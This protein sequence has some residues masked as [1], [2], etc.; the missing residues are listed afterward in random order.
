M[1]V[2]IKYTDGSV[3]VFYEGSTGGSWK[4][5]IYELDDFKVV[6]YVNFYNNEWWNAGTFHID[7]CAVHY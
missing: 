4:I 1:K 3:D 6:S 7:Y 5:S 2:S